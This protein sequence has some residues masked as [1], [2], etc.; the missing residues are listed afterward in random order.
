[1]Q[2]LFSLCHL[3]SFVIADV[4][5]FLNLNSQNAKRQL[6]SNVNTLTEVTAHPIRSEALKVQP[7]SA[8]ATSCAKFES[9]RPRMMHQHFDF[10][11]G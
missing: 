11:S 8:A 2:D 7:A 1:M 10:T 3:G 9:F 6:S 5:L 4:A